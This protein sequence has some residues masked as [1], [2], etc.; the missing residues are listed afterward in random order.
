MVTLVF[1]VAWSVWVDDVE[2]LWYG[3][4]TVV[5]FS[6]FDCAIKGIRKTEDPWNSSTLLYL[7]ITG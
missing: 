2:L 6:T 4:L 3:I 1:G 7:L 5:Q